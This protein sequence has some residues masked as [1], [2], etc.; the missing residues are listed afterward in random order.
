MSSVTAAPAGRDL[1]STVRARAPAPAVAACNGPCCAACWAP[2]A[3][4]ACGRRRPAA[5]CAGT[6]AAAEHGRRRLLSYVVKSGCPQNLPPG[7]QEPTLAWR[8]CFVSEQAP[9]VALCCRRAAHTQGCCCCCGGHGQEPAGS[10]GAGPAHSGRLPLSWPYEGAAEGRTAGRVPME[11]LR[12][13][14]DG[15]PRG[16]V[17]APAFK[18]LPPPRRRA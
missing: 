16:Q 3:A 6:A 13:A 8:A 5:L 11:G 9:A 12:C 1:P 4:A 18:P 7:Q 2:A 14:M 15:A 10:L 17:H